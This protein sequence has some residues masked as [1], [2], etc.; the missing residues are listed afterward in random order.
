MESSR[1]ALRGKDRMKVSPTTIYLNMLYFPYLHLVLIIFNTDCAQYIA[2]LLPGLKGDQ[3][4]AS[5]RQ[6]TDTVIFDLRKS[7][8]C[9]FFFFI[10]FLLLEGKKIHSH[11]ISRGKWENPA[12]QTG[13]LQ[14]VPLKSLSTE[15]TFPFKAVQEVP[16]YLTCFDVN[17]FI[18]FLSFC[19]HMGARGAC[20]FLHPPINPGLL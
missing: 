14:R 15:S 20:V 13:A 17:F 1:C 19:I 5:V 16:S 18:L 8:V 11:S 2:C 10:F 7:I 12:E 3:L 4:Q 9:L 6:T